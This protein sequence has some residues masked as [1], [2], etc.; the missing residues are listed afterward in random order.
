MAQRIEIRS[1]Q[2][3]WL[4]V[5]AA[6]AML[7][8]VVLPLPVAK[9]AS[10]PIEFWDCWNPSGHGSCTGSDITP[11]PSSSYVKATPIGD[12]QLRYR[13]SPCRHVWARVIVTDS[14]T[15]NNLWATRQTS[16]TGTTSGL[17]WHSSGNSRWSKMLNDAGHL[18]YA[19][20]RVNGVNYYTEAY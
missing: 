17:A 14:G 7:L 20:A 3:R 9:A 5:V 18:T 10:C 13:T 19:A 15:L 8:L 1:E 12:L 6:L 16:P 2:V 11:S 4:V